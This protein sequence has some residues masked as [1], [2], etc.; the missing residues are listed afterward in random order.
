MK[1]IHHLSKFK[2]P[3]YT[4]KLNKEDCI[5]YGSNKNIEQSLI[6]LHGTICIL[7]VFTNGETLSIA[8]LNK[9]HIINIKQNKNK[10]E[11][12]YYKALA[13][14]SVYVISF[15]WQNIIIEEKVPMIICTKLIE[16]HQKTI[17]RHEQ[18]NH[19]ITH[20]YIKHRIIQLILF[21][22][23]EFGIVKK[24]KQSFL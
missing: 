21:L 19:I 11:H 17:Y 8:I 12:Y 3:F 20:K 5:L 9:D 23:Q 15:Q 24:K 14:E 22:C 16:A 10:K 1:W 6:I 4:Y 18:M 7:K 2:V 13:L